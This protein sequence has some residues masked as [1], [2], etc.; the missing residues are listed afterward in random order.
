MSNNN[1]GKED[2]PSSSKNTKSE[3][4][5][6]IE[7]AE[8][9]TKEAL[10]ALQFA[11]EKIDSLNEQLK[12]EKETFE[13]LKE[14]LCTTHFP[15]QVVLNIGGKKFSTSIDTLKKDGNNFFGAMFSG[16]HEVTPDKDGTY[17][18]DRDGKHFRIILNYLRTGELLFP[19]DDK[20]LKKELL[21]EVEFYQ[22]EGILELL[23]PQTSTI[24]FPDSSILEG[25]SNFCETLNQ[26]VG[27]SSSS[28][29][30]AR[31]WRLLYKGSR[32]G[33]VPSTFHSRCDNQ[34]ATYTLFKMGGNIFGGYNPHAWNSSSGYSNG[35]GSFLFVLCNSQGTPPTQYLNKNASNGAYNLP[36]H[37]PAFGAGPDFYL[38]NGTKQITFNTP[39]SYNTPSYTVFC[40]STSG[41]VD[42]V[43][44]YGN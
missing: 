36:G 27:G 31:V 25:R 21:K 13:N 10:K 5:C 35:S 20:I 15:N 17:F 42:E 6:A 19:E 1:K 34:G 43:E 44:V 30:S 24:T 33:F 32:D 3:W 14:K 37:G 2:T 12:Q 4:E 7:D 28:S 16:L 38:V 23:K 29:G 18:I 40:S 8:I 11:K 9:K 26:W 22:I 39:N 41:N